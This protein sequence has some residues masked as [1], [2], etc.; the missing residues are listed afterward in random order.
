MTEQD[1]LHLIKQAVKILN[2]TVE[3]L[4]SLASEVMQKQ[5]SKEITDYKLNFSQ[6]GKEKADKK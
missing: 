1:L 3:N 4:A 2:T 6:K 5:D